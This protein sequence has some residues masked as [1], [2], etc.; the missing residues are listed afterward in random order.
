MILIEHPDPAVTRSLNKPELTRF[1]S[2]AKRAASLKGEVTVLLA[3]DSRLRQLNREFRRKNKPTDVLSFPAGDNPYG[4]AGD[5]AISLDTAGRQAKE[6]RHS[7]LEELRVLILH[8]ILH[9]TGM[10]HEADHGE[11]ADKELK[12]R[13]R[14]GLKTNLIQRATSQRTG[15]ETRA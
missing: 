15:K 8:G 11:M 13:T 4:L 7:R 5:L 3:D 14:L 1:L 9:L 6:F 10:D 2:R 12:L